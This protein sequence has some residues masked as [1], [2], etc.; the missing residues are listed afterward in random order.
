MDTSEWPEHSEEPIG[1]AGG[2]ETRAR[3]AL[4]AELGIHEAD[5]A[6]QSELIDSDVFGALRWLINEL[7]RGRL[8]FRDLDAGDWALKLVTGGGTK[9]QDLIVSRILANW[10]RESAGLGGLAN[11]E[12]VSVLRQ[13]ERSVRVWTRSA[14][15]RGY[16]ACLRGFLHERGLQI[17]L[18]DAEGHSVAVRGTRPDDVSLGELGDWWLDRPQDEELFEAFSLRVV[19]QMSEGRSVTAARTCAELLDR[20]SQAG[21]RARLLWLAG[22][23]HY[24]RGDLE[25]AEAKFG[26]ATEADPAFLRAWRS[27]GATRIERGHLGAAANAFEQALALDSQDGWS[28]ELMADAYGRAEDPDAGLIWLR[29]WVEAAPRSLYARHR[30][31]LGLEL[32]GE[33]AEA[34]QT[35]RRLVSSSPSPDA[36]FVDWA[37][38]TRAQIGG[39]KGKRAGR[40][41]QRAWSRAAEAHWWALWLQAVVLEA[42]GRVDAASRMAARARETAGDWAEIR[43]R[44]HEILDD[45]VAADSGLWDGVD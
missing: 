17:D 22:M 42:Q 2:S 26:L 10:E 3:L 7:A 16:L 9:P 27:L 39:G 5:L 20:A 1:G 14:D 12:L 33:S 15:S 37:A 21:M 41:L 25:P 13:V 38:W 34:G 35:R 24:H 18:V 44:A 36:D 19:R 45:L 29:R 4:A 40:L 8:P 31:T 43:D 11:A 23:V 28:Y 30:L 32:A 6:W